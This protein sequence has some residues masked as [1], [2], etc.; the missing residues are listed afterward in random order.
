MRKKRIMRDMPLG[1]VTSFAFFAYFAALAA[2]KSTIAVAG[3][4]FWRLLI[5]MDEPV[6]EVRRGAGGLVVA[7]ANVVAAAAR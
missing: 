2:G 7:N 3:A 1:A 5:L 4:R 6:V